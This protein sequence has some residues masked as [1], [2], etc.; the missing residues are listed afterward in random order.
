[1]SPVGTYSVV[2]TVVDPN[3]KAGNYTVALVNG[4]LTVTPVLLTGTADDKSR[5]YGQTNPVFT[6]TYSG[7][8]NNEDASIVTGELIGITTAETN[9]PI[10]TYPISVSGQSAPNYTIQYVDGTLTVTP[11]ALTVKATDKS[12]VYGQ[13]DPSFMV[14]YI[15]FVNG[16]TET[17]L[18]GTLSLSREPGEAVGG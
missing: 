18:G 10:G 9:S 7:F 4:T 12:K 5:A 1:T 11:Y 13:A 2:P 3:G 8:V 6:V 14:T 16:E 17:S 15:G